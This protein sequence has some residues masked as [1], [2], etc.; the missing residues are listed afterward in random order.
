MEGLR[1]L[2]V[3]C[4][5]LFI[6]LLVSSLASEDFRILT[7]PLIQQ[8][9]QSF[10]PKVL[11]HL[12]TKNI[13]NIKS[14]SHWTNWGQKTKVETSSFSLAGWTYMDT[15]FKIYC[16]KKCYNNRK[17]FFKHFLTSCKSHPSVYLQGEAAWI[18]AFCAASD[19]LLDLMICQKELPLSQGLAAIEW[20]FVLLGVHSAKELSF[21]LWLFL[22][23][24][25]FSSCLW[26][27]RVILSSQTSKYNL[28]IQV[29]WSPMRYRV[30]NCIHHI[31]SK[32]T[33]DLWVLFVAL[34]LVLVDVFL[35]CFLWRSWEFR[36]LRMTLTRK[37]SRNMR[38]DAR[39]R[40]YVTCT[41]RHVASVK[42]NGNKMDT[43]I[44]KISL[45]WR[46]HWQVNWSPTTASHQLWVARLSW[47]LSSINM[48]GVNLL[49]LWRT[50][51]TSCNWCNLFRQRKTLH[52]TVQLWKI[53]ENSTFGTAGWCRR[54]SLGRV[55]VCV[56]EKKRTEK[57]KGIRI[58]AE[59]CWCHDYTTLHW[60]HVSCLRPL[61]CLDMELPKHTR[62]LCIAFTYVSFFLAWL[63]YNE[64]THSQIK[65]NNTPVEFETLRIYD[66]G[67]QRHY[68]IA[69]GL[70]SSSSAWAAFIVELPIFFAL[71]SSKRPKTM[72]AC[73]PLVAFRVV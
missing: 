57:W 45:L 33:S 46:L 17:G 66:S 67:R 3:F 51:A 56:G 43:K 47:E 32:H 52:K 23:G 27:S 35:R 62:V 26:H 54:S 42:W 16:Y 7:T 71:D 24:C 6:T 30:F 8:A 44:L 72:D 61:F 13:K 55:C 29:C 2:I 70:A 4:F 12:T 31:S 10:L 34:I 40:G 28:E 39:I 25:V 19:E 63:L 69:L 18:P 49:R 48:I 68:E 20:L 15:K 64:I 14:Q 41:C 60:R 36:G 65:L 58:F 53:H 59:R 50:H 73:F 22:C 1:V 37:P 9:R 5:I 38:K 11:Q 21:K